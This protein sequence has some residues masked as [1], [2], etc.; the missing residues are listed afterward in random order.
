MSTSHQGVCGWGIPVPGVTGPTLGVHCGS[1]PSTL[2]PHRD[3][4]LPGRPRSDGKISVGDPER[5]PLPFLYTPGV[6]PGRTPLLLY[7]PRGTLF[8]VRCRNARVPVL[9]IGN[10]TLSR[11]L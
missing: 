3:L 10:E 9:F 5:T 4:D 8:G 1:E 6:P 7:A 11:S 2:L